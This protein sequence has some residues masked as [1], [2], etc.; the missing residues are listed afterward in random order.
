LKSRALDSEPHLPIAARAAIEV[1]AL[2]LAARGRRQPASR[3]CITLSHGMEIPPIAARTAQESE[4]AHL[5]RTACA[6]AQTGEYLG[7]P[8]P[9][10]SQLKGSP[11][12]LFFWAHWCADCKAE[13][14]ISGTAALPSSK[15]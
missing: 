4:S 15:A 9:R 8:L 11:W 6:C 3:C 1:Q 7:S 13:A 10:S 5:R 12:L 14:P 2:A